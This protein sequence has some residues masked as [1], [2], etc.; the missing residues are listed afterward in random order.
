MGELFIRHLHLDDEPI[1]RHLPDSSRVPLL[2][3]H[4]Q[5]VDFIS[6]VEHFPGKKILYLNLLCRHISTTFCKITSSTRLP[7]GRKHEK[8]R[9]SADASK[10]I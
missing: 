10:V 7:S 3:S 9:R 4:L 8:R 2:S 1:R 6:F 5:K